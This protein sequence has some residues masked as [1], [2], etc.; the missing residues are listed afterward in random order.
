VTHPTF[1]VPAAQFHQEN[2]MQEPAVYLNGR[3][4]PASQAA[5]KI[6]AQVLNARAA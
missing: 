2:A 4:V 1:R 6:Y 3:F 5:V